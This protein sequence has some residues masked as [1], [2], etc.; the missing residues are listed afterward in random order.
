MWTSEC[1]DI[2]IVP[3]C[4]DST[5]RL[6]SMKLLLSNHFDPQTIMSYFSLLYR[7]INTMK[8]EICK[9]HLPMQLLD[10]LIISIDSLLLHVIG[11]SWSNRPWIAVKENRAK[12]LKNYIKY[13]IYLQNIKGYKMVPDYTKIINRQNTQD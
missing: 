6:N 13:N 2:Q 9:I 4:T 12:N 7:D 1:I 10:A 11:Q 5:Y 8:T 3:M